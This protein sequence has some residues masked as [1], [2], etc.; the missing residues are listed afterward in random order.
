MT[1]HPST[2]DPSPAT[3]TRRPF[4]RLE[5][6]REVHEYALDNGRGLV[7]RAIEWGGIVTAIEWPDRDGRVD[8]IVLALPDLAAYEAPNPSIGALV[9]RCANRIDG[10]RFRLDGDVH[11][12]SLNS[13]PHSLHGGVDGFGRRRW[14]IAPQAPAVDGSVAI[15]LHLVSDDGDQGYPGRLEATVRYTVTARDEWRIDY[16][17]TTDRP[18][19]VNLTHHGYFN[20]AG[21]GSVLDHRLQLV[22][23]RFDTV[24]ARLIPQAAVPVDG[25]P[26]DFRRSTRIGERIRH[27]HPQ[28]LRPR[29]YDHHWWLDAPGHDGVPAFAARLEHPASGRAVEISTTEPGIQFYSGNFLDGSLVGAGGL[30]FRQGDGLCLETQHAPDSPNRPDVPSITLRPGETFRSSTVH[31]FRRDAAPGG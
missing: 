16:R 17:A 18:T 14:T 7:V 22:A 24:D 13:P 12:L 3:V 27:A 20:L 31:R 6:G 11:Q 4:G 1:H 5:D 21:G 8:N 26:F 25:T 30:A 19:I 9:G 29:G 15:E 28:L 23:S 10:G 2:P